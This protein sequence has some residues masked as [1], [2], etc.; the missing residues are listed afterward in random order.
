MKRQ[1]DGL[2]IALYYFWAFVFAVILYAGLHCPNEIVRTKLL[3][4]L[5]VPAVFLFQAIYFTVRKSILEKL[6]CE[7]NKSFCIVEGYGVAWSIMSFYYVIVSYKGLSGETHQL[8]VP[9]NLDDYE[10]LKKGTKIPC[11]IKNELCYVLN[12]SI[13]V[14]E[15]A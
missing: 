6:E 3:I 8:K 13:K 9:C 2:T 5:V 11:L 14:K 1:P 12:E 10:K 7:E 4:C 15:E